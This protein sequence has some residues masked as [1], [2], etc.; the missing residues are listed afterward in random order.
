MTCLISSFAHLSTVIIYK[1]ISQED[2]DEIV[3]AFCLVKR[4]SLSETN[5]GGSAKE[6]HQSGSR[7]SWPTT[8]V[9]ATSQIPLK[10]L[11]RCELI[12]NQSLICI[13][14]GHLSGQ[15]LFLM[16][17]RSSFAEQSNLA[18][19]N[20]LLHELTLKQATNTRKRMNARIRSRMTRNVWNV[21]NSLV[22]MARI[23]MD[24]ILNYT[25]SA[26]ETSDARILHDTSAERSSLS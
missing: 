22:R 18:W 11:H 12:W 15:T 16:Q 26:N 4:S 10:D 20:A 24:V 9:Q 23:V 17:G 14:H 13:W 5:L 19:I 25:F 2:L 3:F 7:I 21:T 6:N 8:F 1:W